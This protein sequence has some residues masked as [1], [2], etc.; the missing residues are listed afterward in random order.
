MLAFLLSKTGIYVI[1][2]IVLIAGLGYTIYQIDQNGYNR[3]VLT[4]QVKYDKL[5]Q[6]VNQKTADEVERQAKAND[7]ALSAQNKI[8]SELQTQ[9]DDLAIKQKEIESE[10][11][12]DPNRNNLSLKSTSVVRI[13]RVR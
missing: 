1:V 7:A 5:I 3:G 6:Q 9:N 13:N 2:G 8:I 11:H 4:E 10:A 12:T